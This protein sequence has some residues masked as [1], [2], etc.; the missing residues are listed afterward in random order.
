[1][2]KS[3]ISGCFL[4]FMVVVAFS[5][6]EARAGGGGGRGGGGARG[7]GARA[8]GGGRSIQRSPS[9]SRAAVARSP[10]VSRDRQISSQQ[11]LRA[12]SQQRSAAFSQQAERTRQ[13]SFDRVQGQLNSQR[14]LNLQNAGQQIRNDR[15]SGQYLSRQNANN[16]KDRLAQTQPGYRNW[17]DNNFFDRVDFHPNYY[18]S[19]VNWWRAA[20]WATLNSA[21]GWGWA[22]P[23][24]YDYDNGSYYADP[25]Y[26]ADSGGS[27]SS[28]Q[29]IQS[30]NSQTGYMPLGVFALS[31]DASQ[32]TTS[33]M[34]LQLAVNN[35]GQIDG[36]YYNSTTDQ[37]HEV[38]GL[39]N[40]TTQEA[41]LQ[42]ADNPNTPFMSVGLYNLTGDQT[43]AQI[44][45]QNGSTQTWT[46]TRVQS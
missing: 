20:N 44:Q 31:R 25:T 21:L 35:S 6:I 41:V 39:V 9:M 24:Y 40:K 38:V 16:L 13:P 33:N 14:G 32:A 30:A 7:G 45:F 19:G 10:Q 4:L 34:F 17:F 1:M 18:N 46:L 2:H 12:V 23:Y 42:L 27:T 11:Q 43:K 36:T 15:V 26:A 3:I 37:A 29:D 28:Y 22:A 8:G 5:D